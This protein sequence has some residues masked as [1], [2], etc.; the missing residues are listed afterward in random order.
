MN[1]TTY[2]AMLSQRLVAFAFALFGPYKRE[3]KR[4][5]LSL[6][7]LPVSHCALCRMQDISSDD[8]CVQ[9]QLS[10]VL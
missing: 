10:W 2:T 8:L 6:L 7:S 5:Y 9:S 4:G 3:L 1:V